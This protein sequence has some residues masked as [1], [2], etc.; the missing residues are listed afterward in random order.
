MDLFNETAAIS[1]VDS[2]PK[3]ILKWKVLTSSINKKNATMSTLYGNDWAFNYSKQN[4]GSFYPVGARIALV[5][6]LQ[7]ADKHWFGANIPGKIKT[8]E[9]IAFENKAGKRVETYLKYEGQ[10]LIPSK[11]DAAFNIKRINFILNQRIAL[12]PQ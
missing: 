1:S 9:I 6:W 8:I 5:T 2:F 4:Q 3:I 7:Q 12:I 10:P 11:T